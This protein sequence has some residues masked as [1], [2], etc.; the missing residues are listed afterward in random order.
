MMTLFCLGGAMKKLLFAVV[1]ILASV[2]IFG[3][4]RAYFIDEWK[5]TA[6]NYKAHFQFHENAA[7]IYE[8]GVEEQFLEILQWMYISNRN[9]LVIEYREYDVLIV[10]ENTFMLTPID[11]DKDWMENIEFKFKRIGTPPKREPFT[12]EVLPA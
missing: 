7:T 6:T 1:F 12:R 4:D 3:I 2:L 8:L 9:V 5:C 11:T 10:D